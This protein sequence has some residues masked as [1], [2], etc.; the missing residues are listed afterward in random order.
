MSGSSKAQLLLQGG[1][2]R[3]EADYH[4]WQGRDLTSE[5][6]VSP[7]MRRADLVI[8]TKF[9]QELRSSSRFVLMR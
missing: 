5:G 9:S 7:P 8:I 1:G 2:G 3:S 4:S 6:P